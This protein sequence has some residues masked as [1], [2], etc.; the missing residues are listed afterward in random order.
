[1]HDESRAV[2]IDHRLAHIERLLEGF[3]P[4]KKCKAI[5][6]MKGLAL[7]GIGFIAGATYGIY[8]DI[9]RS[10]CSGN[11]ADPEAFIPHEPADE[12]QE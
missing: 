8:Q 5:T 11:K 2:L 4:P 12:S 6:F 3:E 10:V 1:M 9:K 7:I